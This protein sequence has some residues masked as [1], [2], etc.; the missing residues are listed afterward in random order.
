ML[1]CLSCTYTPYFA[2]CFHLPFLMPL[3]A[4]NLTALISSSKPT[5]ATY[6]F[7]TMVFHLSNMNDTHKAYCGILGLVDDL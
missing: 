6:C 2:L 1:T 3:S 4:N 5:S 7:R